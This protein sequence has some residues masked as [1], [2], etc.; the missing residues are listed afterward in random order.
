MPYFLFR[1]R[2]FAALYLVLSFFILPLVVFLLS[3]AGLAVMYS[4]IGSVALI[5]AFVSLVN[6]LQVRP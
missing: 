3:L 2:W 4:V 5:I 1:Y 6:F